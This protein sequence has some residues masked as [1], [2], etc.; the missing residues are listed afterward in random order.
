M[1]L[2]EKKK[3]RQKKAKFS[4]A[5]NNTTS[6]IEKVNWVKNNAV[7]ATG[8]KGGRKGRGGKKGSRGRKK[9]EVA[10]ATYYRGRNCFEGKGRERKEKNREEEKKS[11]KE[12][13]GGRG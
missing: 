11:M 7:C 8:K 12:R 13:R 5:W 6:R 4:T 1:H 3:W 2:R 10:S 9:M